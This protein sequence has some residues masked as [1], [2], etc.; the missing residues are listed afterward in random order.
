ML[1]LCFLGLYFEFGGVRCVTF[2]DGTWLGLLVGRYSILWCVVNR[3]K[4][5]D[6]CVYVALMC[7]GLFAL[8]WVLC[9]EYVFVVLSY[10]CAV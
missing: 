6:G 9:Y 5:A 8:G 10:G 3:L 2:D 4:G 1:L 7:P